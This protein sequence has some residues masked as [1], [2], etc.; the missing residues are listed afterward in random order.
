MTPS[1]AVAILAAAVV[2][3]LFAHPA[4]VKAGDFPWL[5]ALG[6]GSAGPL[7]YCSIWRAPSVF[8]SRA[9]PLSACWNWCLHPSKCGLST[10]KV[11]ASSHWLAVLV[12]G[13]AVANVWLY[14]HC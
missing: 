1:L 8:P 11:Q 10:A 12:I 4:E 6:P 14:A 5:L 13:V 9:R 7:A 2:S 3:L